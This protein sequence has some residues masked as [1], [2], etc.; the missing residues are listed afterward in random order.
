M[1]EISFLGWISYEF[2]NQLG[3]LFFKDVKMEFF[4]ICTA[5][6]LSDLSL[7]KSQTPKEITSNV[8]YK[9]TCFSDTSLAYTGKTKRHL[10]ARSD[11]HLYLLRYVL[12]QQP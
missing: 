7:L 1:I 12:D 8:V 10:V 11:D 9:F 5:L 6:T 4:P 3:N 2:K